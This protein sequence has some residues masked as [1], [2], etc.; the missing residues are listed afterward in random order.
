MGFALTGDKK[1][2]FFREPDEMKDVLSVKEERKT[3]MI[4]F[5]KYV[6]QDFPTATCY[7]IR[8]YTSREDDI[9]T[10]LGII[11]KSYW[12]NGPHEGVRWEFKTTPT[13]SHARATC[14]HPLSN[15]YPSTLADSKE[16]VLEWF[17]H[18]MTESISKGRFD[19]HR[20]SC[21]SPNFSKQGE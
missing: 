21:A 14:K 7:E 20:G 4:K 8:L 13:E 9:F 2:S 1:F 18:V 16:L 6:R 11:Q 15:C 17:S 12:G 19:I 3:R 5:K 10:S